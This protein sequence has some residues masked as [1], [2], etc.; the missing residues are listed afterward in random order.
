[1]PAIGRRKTVQNV[2]WRIITRPQGGITEDQCRARVGIPTLKVVE[3]LGGTLA[4][5]H[6]GNVV[7]G[8]LVLQHVGQDGAVL[9]RVHNASILRETRGHLSLATESNDDLT[10][11]ARGDLARLGITRAHDKV[12][13]YAIGLSSRYDIDNFLPVVHNVLKTLRAPAHIVLKFHTG[14]QECPQVGEVDEAVLVVQIVQECEATAGVAESRQILDEGNLHARARDQHTC[15][16][17]KLLLA[18]EEAHLG[19]E[20][21]RGR[22][23]QS[24]VHGV[25]QSDGDSQGGR[26]KAHAEQIMHLVGGDGAEQCAVDGSLGARRHLGQEG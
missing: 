25:V 15:V 8:R 24:R 21:A 19:L 26:A 18:L 2:Q 11:S 4:G 22:A 12:V 7:R 16:P 14:R 13:N 9:G 3:D 20:G 6:D 1:M 5:A 17:G 10:S 23:G